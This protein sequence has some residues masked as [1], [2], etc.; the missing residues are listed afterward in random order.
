MATEIE[1]RELIY[2]RLGEFSPYNVPRQRG[3]PKNVS[4]DASFSPIWTP[5][6]V[7]LGSEL[8]PPVPD[9]LSTWALVHVQHETREATSLSGR[10]ADRRG[11]VEVLVHSRIGEQS[12]EAV[13]MLLT[14]ELADVLDL[15]LQT[16]RFSDGTS[17]YLTGALSEELP[18]ESKSKWH[19]FRITAPFQWHERAR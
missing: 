7:V 13:G 9:H 17:L 4:L 3:I 6:N 12:A 14:R 2:R 19:Q 18:L 16:L 15:S 1:A 10:R 5:R 11:N 8:A